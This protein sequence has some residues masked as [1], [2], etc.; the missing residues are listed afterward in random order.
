MKT[1]TALFTVACLA[2]AI[3][4]VAAPADAQNK[5][6]KKGKPPPDPVE[7]P[8]I[9]TFDDVCAA[10]MIRSDGLGSY[11][12][13]FTD[14][15]SASPGSLVIHFGD[16]RAPWVAYGEQVDPGSCN[17]GPCA[18]P[19]GPYAAWAIMVNPVIEPD[20]GDYESFGFPNM[21]ENE[22]GRARMKINFQAPGTTG[23]KG[24]G[25]PNRNPVWTLRFR[26]A[27]WPLSTNVLVERLPD[28]D[29]T[30]RWEVRGED[31]CAQG[32]GEIC[33]LATLHSIDNIDFGTYI[34]PF[35]MIVEWTSEGS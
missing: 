14:H 4:L 1:R 2:L 24:R 28:V 7:P 34:M 33:N 18:P 11:E 17:P 27:S 10:C 21:A 20:S 5:N 19:D 13:A 30:Q 12:A 25:K 35:K 6:P 8:V 16:E 9:V 32:P 22:I 31:P 29:G 15:T 3:M 26:E 23:K